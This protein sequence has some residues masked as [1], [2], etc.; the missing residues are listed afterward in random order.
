M[1]KY[2]SLFSGIG[3]F[4]LGI[5]S[6]SD[7]TGIETEC[8][9]ASEFDPESKAKDINKQPARIIY[10]K[11]FGE[12]PHG[13]IT[14]INASD[15][16]NHDI[17][18]GGFPCQNVSI[19]GKREGLCG[20]KSALFFDIVRIVRE[21]QPEYILLENVAGL[22]SSNGGWDFARILI[23]LEDA[24]YECEWEVRNTK[25]YLPQNRERVFIVG[26]LAGSERSRY[27]IFPIGEGTCRIDERAGQ[28]TVNTLTAGGH[29]GGHHSSMTLICDS[30]QGRKYQVRTE[31]IAPLRANSGAGHNNIVCHSTLPRSSKSGKGGV[32]NLSRADGVTYCLDANNNV[33]IEMCGKVRRLMPVECEMLQG[34]PQY[35]SHISVNIHSNTICVDH[36]KSYV[37]VVMK[38]HKSPKHVLNAENGKLQKNVKYVGESSFREYLQIKKRAQK[39]VH[40]NCVGSTVGIHKHGRLYSFANFVESQN[41]CHQYIKPENF[42]QM[43]AGINTMCKKIIPHGKVGLHQN[44]QFSIHQKNGKTFVKLYGNETMLPAPNAEIDLIILKKHLKCIT[45]NHSNSNSLDLNSIISFFYVMAAIT[46]CIQ[47]RTNIK[48]SLNLDIH[49]IFGYTSGIADTNR[50]KCIGNSVS[51]PVVADIIKKILKTMAQSNG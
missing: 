45:L 18:V 8:V 40:I 51:V 23:E 1:I 42:V 13:D 47:T 29:S 12:Y 37:N 21:K 48:D 33:A 3:G 38:N 15:V 43:I 6:A 41:S 17:L 34:F 39:S 9:F 5:E 28:T 49:S 31:C 50:Y 19:A 20:A 36:Q 10:N 44:G 26:H 32:G 22:L 27:K 30:G 16:P 7:Q 2:A 4:E 11:R 14:K 35:E 25:A 24:G 46:G